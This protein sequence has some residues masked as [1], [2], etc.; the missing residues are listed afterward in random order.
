[1]LFDQSRACWKDRRKG[2]KQAA[3][4]WPEAGSDKACDYSHR[5]T[6]HK[7]GEIPVPARL[8][9]GGSLELDDHE[10]PC[11]SD[12]SWPV[13]LSY[14]TSSMTASPPIISTVSPGPCV[15]TARASGDTYRSIEI[16][17]MG[18]TTGQDNR[19]DD[20]TSSTWNGLETTTVR[21]RP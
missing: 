21:R 5:A 2:E 20:W 7:S 11:A 17:W 4:D 3:N 12:N 6:E 10:S 8:T 16:E 9:K 18:F 13:T 15:R 1:M 14:S 19:G